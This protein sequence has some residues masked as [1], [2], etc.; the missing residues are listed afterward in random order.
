MTDFIVGFVIGI[1][2]VPVYWVLTTVGMLMIPAWRNNPYM[3]FVGVVFCISIP[4]GIMTNL[5]ESNLVGL[6]MG[7]TIGGIWL[8]NITK[9]K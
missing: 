3:A 8:Y 1:V 9:A 7:V 6:I 4:L 5:H 2:A